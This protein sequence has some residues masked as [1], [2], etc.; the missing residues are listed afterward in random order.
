[1]AQFLVKSCLGIQGQKSQ[2]ATQAEY[3]MATVPSLIEGRGGHKIGKTNL[4]LPRDLSISVRI[5][6]AINNKSDWDR[7]RTVRLFQRFFRLLD[8]VAGNG[9]LDQIA[10]QTNDVDSLK[11][12][13]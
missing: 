8:V 13:A 11:I 10:I 9:Q 12:E 2:D 5:T 3:K 4:D 6:Q 1:M 7:R